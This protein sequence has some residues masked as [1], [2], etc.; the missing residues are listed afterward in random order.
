MSFVGEIRA[1]LHMC[2]EQSYPSKQLNG[3]ARPIMADKPVVGQPPLF[4]NVKR[5]S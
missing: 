1:R 2:T 5:T 3:V 4:V